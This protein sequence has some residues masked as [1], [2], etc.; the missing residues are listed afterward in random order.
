MQNRS[1]VILSLALGVGLVVSGCSKK[2]ESAAG[3]TTGA[4]ASNPAPSPTPLAPEDDTPQVRD[5]QASVDAYVKIKQQ[6]PS[7]LEQLVR[8]GFLVSLPSAPPGKRF[9]Y[10][11][12]TAR[13]GVV[14]K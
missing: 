14:Q 4:D 6:K 3:N 12:N 7:S 2:N 10:D 5:L 11:A 13:I 9:S 1:L 8:D